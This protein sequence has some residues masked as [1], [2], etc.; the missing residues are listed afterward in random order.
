MKAIKKH[1]IHLINLKIKSKKREI[2]F[3]MKRLFKIINDT[4]YLDNSKK[5]SKI[6]LLLIHHP[7]LF[8]ITLIYLIQ[9][10]YVKKK[11]FSY[12]FIHILV[13]KNKKIKRISIVVLRQLQIWISLNL[14][15]RKF[16][17]KRNQHKKINYLKLKS[18]MM[19]QNK[20]VR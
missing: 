9:I 7:N 4:K 12:L 1:R 5:K 17:I 11:F 19:Y 6:F 2:G 8:N 13:P 18:Q 3:M 14:H 20:E 16:K 15:L 10:L